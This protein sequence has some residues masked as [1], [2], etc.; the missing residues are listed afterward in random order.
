LYLFFGYLTVLF[1][2]LNVMSGGKMNY[3][4]NEVEVIVLHFMISV[5]E[6][7]HDQAAGLP[8]TKLQPHDDN[9]E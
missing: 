2:L 6:E 8:A 7:N 3:Y 4:Y 1:E 9:K 5:L